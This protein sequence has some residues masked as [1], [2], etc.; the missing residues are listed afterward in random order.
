MR[1]QSLWTAA[2]AVAACGASSLLACSVPDY[3][4][5]PRA[6]ESAQAPARRGPRWTLTLLD[7]L[8]EHRTDAWEMSLT[9]L[10]AGTV[11]LDE[12]PVLWRKDGAATAPESLGG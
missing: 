8:G 7:G 11:G 2:R 3:N 10:V 12:R 6:S 5:S 9:A 4:G 1:Q